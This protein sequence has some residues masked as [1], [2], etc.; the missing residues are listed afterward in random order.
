MENFSLSSEDINT[1]L[2]DLDEFNIDRLITGISRNNLIPTELINE[3]DSFENVILSMRNRTEQ[4]KENSPNESGYIWAATLG[5]LALNRITKIK[6]L[7]NNL[8]E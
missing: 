5:D 4:F 1:E 8:L 2:I 6:G 7:I 3:L